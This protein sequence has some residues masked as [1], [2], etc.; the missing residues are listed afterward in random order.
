MQNHPQ[1]NLVGNFVVLSPLGCSIAHHF[2]HPSTRRGI[3]AISVT[4]AATQCKTGRIRVGISG[5]NY[6]PW[7][8][9]FYPPR[10]PHARELAYA[11]ERF[12]TIEINGTFYSLQRPFSFLRWSELTPPDFLFSVKGSRYIT[13]MLRLR[14]VEQALANFFASGLLLLGPKLG[15]ILWQFP[16]TFSFNASLLEAFFQL[17]PRTTAEAADLSQRHD[18]RVEGRACTETDKN[19]PM[20][21]AVE[22]RHDSFLTEE[23]IRLLRRYRIAL[24][25]ADTVSW[26]R[27]V[28][29]TADF[30]YCRLHGSRELYASG[31]G[32]KAIATW[33]DRIA[34]WAG[35]RPPAG[36]RVSTFSATEACPHDVYVY[37]DNDMKVR[38]PADALSLERRLAKLGIAQPWK[39]LQ[40]I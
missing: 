1:Q 35:G 13:H 9:V 12:S 10:L 5:W 24:V 37:F 7:R 21:H 33:A 36:T 30:V 29:A 38:A 25:C 18:S 27:L 16:P 32:P 6:A 23:F 17:L 14:N 39:A 3:F 2:P 26:P 15:P 8:R 34:A 19:R 22:I 20:R 31:Y 11:A 28:D 40:E 4:M